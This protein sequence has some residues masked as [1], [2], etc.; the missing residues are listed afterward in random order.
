MYFASLWTKAMF[1]KNDT[2][3]FKKSHSSGKCSHESLSA[4]LTFRTIFESLLL[5]SD[6][7]QWDISE[8]TF[9]SGIKELLHDATPKDAIFTNPGF[10]DK[11]RMPLRTNV[12]FDRL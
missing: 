4:P 1:N 12:V 7:G 9:L 2:V 3:Y 10:A 8:D 5:S 6:K 11:N